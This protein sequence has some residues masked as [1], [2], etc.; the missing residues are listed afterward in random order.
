MGSTAVSSSRGASMYRNYWG[1]GAWLAPG[2][3]LTA[4]LIV[5]DPSDVIEGLLVMVPGTLVPFLFSFP[6]R[7][8]LDDGDVVIR[9]VLR[10]RSRPIDSL[11]V[12]Q[13][14]RGPLFRRLEFRFRRGR[15]VVRENESAIELVKALLR[16]NPA[17]EF[18]ISYAGVGLP[19]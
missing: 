18:H 14:A 8:D 1:L 13:T 16:A 6:S 17:I 10:E 19:E 5:L 9:Y 11:E 7:V 15:L 2:T 12:I 3:L 4:T